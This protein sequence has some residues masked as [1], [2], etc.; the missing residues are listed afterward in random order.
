MNKMNKKYLKLAAFVATMTL[1]VGCTSTQPEKKHGT[2]LAVFPRVNK[3]IMNRTIPSDKEKNYYGADLTPFPPEI[4]DWIINTAFT[5]ENMEKPFMI[6][7]KLKVWWSDNNN[8]ILCEASYITAE[9]YVGAGTLKTWGQGAN[10]SGSSDIF[11]TYGK[12]AKFQTLRFKWELTLEVEKLLRNDL[13]YAE[14]IE[15]AMKLS[16]EI[17]YDWGK[18]LTTVSVKRTP[19]LR[20]AVC[21][22]YAN[23]VREKALSLSCVQSVQTWS[24]SDHAWN[25]LK[26]TDGR[27][28]YVDLTW[29]DNEH[30]NSKTGKIYQ[31]DDYSWANITFNEELFRFSSVGY[32]D[33]VFHHNIGRLDGE[34]SK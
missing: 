21:S 11:N 16:E 3:W 25:V 29:F 28:L 9:G 30:I 19:G 4:R 27:I 5:K 34:I 6:N 7:S 20:Y 32:G 18:I 1:F 13:M 26:L 2:D 15:F 12:Y 23:E 33:K 31:T 14:I 8:S 22:G 17:E 24:S 10:Y